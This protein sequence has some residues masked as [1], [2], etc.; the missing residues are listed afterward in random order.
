MNRVLCVGTV[1]GR[2][3]RTFDADERLVLRRVYHCIIVVWNVLLVAIPP[4]YVHSAH[5]LTG[6]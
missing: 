6:Q 5:V 4:M 1:P 3:L 2:L